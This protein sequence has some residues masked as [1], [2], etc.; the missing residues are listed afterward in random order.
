MT[1][2][3]KG[4]TFRW[5]TVIKFHGRDPKTKRSM[6]LCLCECGNEKVYATF[7]LTGNSKPAE[8]CGDCKDHIK[9]KEAYISWMGAK[10]RTS[11]PTNKDYPSYGGRGIFMCD[12]WKLDFKNFYRDMGDPPVDPISGERMSLERI[13][14]DKGYNKENCCW[15]NRY[16][17]QKNKS[18]TPVL[19]KGKIMEG[20]MQ[21]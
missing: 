6:W 7:R 5:L 3:L 17:Q 13:D 12:E 14:N 10:S 9:R 11:Q 16:A 21:S 19:I 4:K 18:S 15:A 8:S 2:Q 20:V 1:Y